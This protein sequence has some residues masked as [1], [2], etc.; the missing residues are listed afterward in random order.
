[1]TQK[2]RHEICRSFYSSVACNSHAGSHGWLNCH[3]YGVSMKDEGLTPEKLLFIR[4][5]LE[6]NDVQ[7]L[8]GP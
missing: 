4:K 7:G 8:A 6:A 1:M 2:G 5:N 3:E